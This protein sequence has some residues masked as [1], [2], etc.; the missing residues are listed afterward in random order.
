M[1]SKD[2]EIITPSGKLKPRPR[3]GHSVVVYEVC[4]TVVYKK[5]ILQVW[6]LNSVN[7]YI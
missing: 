3:Y 2:M 1:I 7:L 6:L 4:T 5:M